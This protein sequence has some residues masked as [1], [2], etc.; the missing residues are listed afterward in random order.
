MPI[1]PDQRKPC[2]EK[3]LRNVPEAIHGP[4]FCCFFSSSSARTNCIAAIS[5]FSEPASAQHSDDCL[6]SCRNGA[7]EISKHGV[8]CVMIPCYGGAAF[9][10]PK[11]SPQ[12]LRKQH[13]LLYSQLRPVLSLAIANLQFD[14]IIFHVSPNTSHR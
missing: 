13:S 3:F 6:C 2:N 12:R 7:L 4:V 9:S 14:I 8:S 5:C 10:P 1:I 11:F